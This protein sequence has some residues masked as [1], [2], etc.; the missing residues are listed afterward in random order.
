MISCI[1]DWIRLSIGFTSQNTLQSSHATSA[2][3]LLAV[4]LLMFQLGRYSRVQISYGTNTEVIRESYVYTTYREAS[5]FRTCSYVLA[6][7]VKSFGFWALHLEISYPEKFSPQTLDPKKQDCLS[8]ELSP[9]S[10]VIY[11]AYWQGGFRL[12]CYLE[13]FT[14]ESGARIVGQGQSVY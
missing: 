7:M 3:T 5:P 9:C 4:M 11:P 1:L 14:R 8:S 12:F 2:T 10:L 6:R 13:Q